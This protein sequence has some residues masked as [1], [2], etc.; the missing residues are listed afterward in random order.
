MKVCEK[1]RDEEPYL[2]YMT[3]LFSS[4]IE[5]KVAFFKNNKLAKVVAGFDSQLQK[6]EVLTDFRVYA[7]SAA[8]RA[9]HH[10]WTNLP[11]PENAFVQKYREFMKPSYCIEQFQNQTNTVKL[12]EEDDNGRNSSKLL[13]HVYGQLLFNP[14]SRISVGFCKEYKIHWNS[15]TDLCERLSQDPEAVLLEENVLSEVE[16]VLRRHDIANVILR[17]DE[18]IQEIEN[19]E[20]NPDNAK[21]DEHKAI[22]QNVI[23]AERKLDKKTKNT[24]RYSPRVEGK[25]ESQ[26][27]MYKDF[28]RLLEQR[29]HYSQLTSRSDIKLEGVTNNTSNDAGLLEEPT[30]LFS[31][32]EMLKNV[33]IFLGNNWVMERDD[34][35][36]VYPYHVH[37]QN[38]VDSFRVEYQ[39]SRGRL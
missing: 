37:L 31:R 14:K 22:K 5:R 20:I 11:Y 28:S 4:S 10:I 36:G 9:S 27:A 3:R 21:E 16:L 13:E 15:K 19:I 39:E 38:Y 23:K 24:I 6:L 34:L 2:H 29:F 35:L 1:R 8:P 12:E 18:E 30:Y 33:D 25:G 17:L 7:I 32:L 26:I